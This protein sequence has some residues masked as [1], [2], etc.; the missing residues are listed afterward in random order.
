MTDSKE[1]LIREAFEQ[2]L[3]TGMKGEP[4]TNR[5]GDL[6]TTNDGEMVMAAPEASFL[7]VVRAYLKDLVDPQGKPKVPVTGVGTGL[8]ASYAKAKLPFG[9]RPS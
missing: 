3:M 6:V 5:E 9:V 8:L 1:P 7:S 2:A 4:M